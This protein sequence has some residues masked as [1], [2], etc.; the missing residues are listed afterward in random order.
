MRDSEFPVK[1]SINW[2][3]RWRQREKWVVQIFIARHKGR[4]YFRNCLAVKK[5]NAEI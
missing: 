2:N 4:K 5:L 3:T 1:E